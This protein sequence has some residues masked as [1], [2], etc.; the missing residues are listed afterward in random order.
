MTSIPASTTSRERVDVPFIRI[1]RETQNKFRQSRK[2]EFLIHARQSHHLRRTDVVSLDLLKDD[3]IHRL[4]R[5]PHRHRSIQ[6]SKRFGNAFF[7]ILA[8]RSENG[9]WPVLLLLNPFDM[10]DDFVV[11]LVHG[12]IRIGKHQIRDQVWRLLLQ[13]L[14]CSPS[15]AFTRSIL[16]WFTFEMSWFPS[17]Q[18]VQEN[19]HPRLVSIIGES[20]PSK[21]LSM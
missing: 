13:P 5:H 7:F 2:A 19:G 14:Q 10:F 6:L 4:D 1:A 3:W 8:G 12:K 15:S 9:A 17:W 18:K 21:N 16:K 11:A 20:L